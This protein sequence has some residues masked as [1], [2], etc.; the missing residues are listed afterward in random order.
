MLLAGH[1]QRPH[2]VD[3]LAVEVFPGGFRLGL[4]GELRQGASLGG[5]IRGRQHGSGTTEGMTHIDLDALE[6]RG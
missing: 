5:R 1:P 2:R 6:R 4:G 3:A